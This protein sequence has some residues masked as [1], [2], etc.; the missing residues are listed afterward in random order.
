M[1]FKNQ[2]D[3]YFDNIKLLLITLVVIGHVIEPLINTYS[4]FRLLY[5][6]IYA[7]HMPLFAFISGY[8]LKNANNKKNILP[9]ISN[10]FIPYIIFQFFLLCI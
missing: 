6:F 1:N 9:K 10:I 5:F 4:N 8:F 7:F 3:Y 2:R